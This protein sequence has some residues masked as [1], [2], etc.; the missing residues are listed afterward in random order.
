MHNIDRV[1]QYTERP[2]YTNQIS[3]QRFNVLIQ[4][5]KTPKPSGG[6]HQHLATTNT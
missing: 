3:M 2:P 1:L 4:R 6:D 5:E